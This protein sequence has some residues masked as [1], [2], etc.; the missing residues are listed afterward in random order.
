MA[1]IKLLPHQ[2]D[3]VNMSNKYN[4]LLGGIG[5]GKSVAGGTKSLRNISLYP[6]ATGSIFA[7]TYRQLM[8]S[9][10]SSFFKTLNDLQI[11]FSFN[12]QRGVLEILKTKILCL[13]LENYD[14]HRGIEIGW[15]WIDEVQD[16]KEEAFQV[17]SGRLR[18]PRGPLQLDLT[19]SAKGFNWVY[20]KFAGKDRNEDFKYIKAKTKD[21]KHLP[22]SYVRSL[23]GQYSSKFAQQELEAEFVE[24]ASGRIYY[25][26]DRD[27]HVRELKD[28]NGQIYIGMDFNVNPMTAVIAKVNNNSI[29]VFDEIYLEHSHTKHACLE[30]IKK[31]YKGCRIIPDF[32]GR[33]M[34][35]SGAGVS[36]LMILEDYGFKIEGSGNPLRMDRYN[37]V[38]KLFE[39]NNLIISP[40]CVNLISDIPLVSYEEGKNT[41]NTDDKMVGHISDALG[42]LAWGTIGLGK[43]HQANRQH[44]F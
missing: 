40:S 17:I 27:V 7:N 12:Q 26:Y 42:Y 24:I 44:Q 2:Y 6:H 41:P 10:L 15:G 1:E 5:S 20:K 39:E 31:G 43:K 23:Y 8:N 16:I 4:L 21:N 28:F 34:K 25:A 32:T 38:N 29:Y 19:G 30:L 13:S 22:E 11:P 36:D 18:D 3:F 35:T 14:V 33:A 37:S 9:T